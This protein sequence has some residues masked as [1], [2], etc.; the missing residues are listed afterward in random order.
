MSKRKRKRPCRICGHWFQPHPRVGARQ[1]VCDNPACQRER[2]RRSCVDW[3]ARHPDWDREN[4]L[5]D[6]LRRSDAEV[7]ADP[8]VSVDPLR[9]LVL[10]VARDAVGMEVH[11][12]TEEIAKVVIGWARDA[13]VP[14][15]AGIK[16]EIR[17][18][19]PPGVRDEIGP[20]GSI[21]YHRHANGDVAPP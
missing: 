11:V 12:V 5:R 3:H 9:S 7:A 8:G 6:R 17:K 20:R 2:H 21:P 15:P 19:L 18:V 14:Y 10:G 4:R 13:V 1:R 16:S